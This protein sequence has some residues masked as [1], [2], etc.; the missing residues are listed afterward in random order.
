MFNKD[1]I[2]PIISTTKIRQSKILKLFFSAYFIDVDFFK[3]YISMIDVFKLNFKK[4]YFVQRFAVSKD[5]GESLWAL[6][7]ALQNTYKEC[8]KD[9]FIKKT[10]Y[11]FSFLSYIFEKVLFNNKCKNKFVLLVKS[12][13]QR[14]APKTNVKQIL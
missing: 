14:C 10:I 4:F 6:P 3:I 13:C 9:F 1:K 8:F 11:K 12:M 7:D 2:K 5:N